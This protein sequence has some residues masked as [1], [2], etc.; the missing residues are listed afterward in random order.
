MIL[1]EISKIGT[2]SFTRRVVKLYLHNVIFICRSTH[3]GQ[4]LFYNE[5]ECDVK[6]DTRI[7]GT[8][9]L[10]P[11]KAKPRYKLSSH[12]LKLSDVLDDTILII[13]KNHS[14]IFVTFLYNITYLRKCTNR[15]KTLSCI[16]TL[17]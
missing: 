5:E 10:K 6:Q 16:C 4:T 12:K 7:Q 15:I 13:K 9:T 2:K 1:G 14:I 11:N 3:W 17:Y 8:I